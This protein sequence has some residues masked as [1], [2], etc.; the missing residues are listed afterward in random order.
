MKKI[1]LFLTLA[2]MTVNIPIMAQNQEKD[3][4]KN[5]KKIEKEAKKAA[6]KAE[7][8]ALYAEA[9]E[10][11]TERKFIIKIDRVQIDNGRFTPVDNRSS[12]FEL[13]DTVTASQMD[14]G[15]TFSTPKLVYGEASDFKFSTD[16]KG[17]PTLELTLR[18]KNSIVPKDIKIRL[19][20]ESNEC[21][22]TIFA[23]KGTRLYIR[24]IL[25]PLGKTKMF[26]GTPLI[27]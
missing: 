1:I 2:I 21:S 25:E 20:N 22:M 6:K 24:G 4:K 23:K 12:F 18:E 7:K 3:S 8:Q 13:N 14:A 26:K 5:A 27:Y 15:S 17:I 16:K 10:A 11:L 19:D 9:T